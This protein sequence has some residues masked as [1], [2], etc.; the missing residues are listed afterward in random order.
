M[1]NGKKVVKST[2]I[3]TPAGERVYLSP[4]E[5]ERKSKSQVVEAYVED[6]GGWVRARLVGA[7]RVIA[8]L[9][10]SGD[11]EKLEAM[12]LLVSETLCNEDGSEYISKESARKLPIPTL[13]NIIGAVAE[14]RKEAKGNG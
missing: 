10:S 8:F 11:V 9:G 6:L 14:A 1:R 12:A 4:E 13:D 5:I 3:A 2:T 7:D